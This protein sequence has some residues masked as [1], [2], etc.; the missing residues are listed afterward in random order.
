[1]WWHVSWLPWLISLHPVV[2]L[3]L[4]VRLR[5]PVLR[6]SIIRRHPLA[7]LLHCLRVIDESLAIGRCGL[8]MMVLVSVSV[9]LSPQ[10]SP[11]AVVAAQSHYQAHKKGSE[12]QYQI[13]G[14]SG[15]RLGRRDLAR[16]L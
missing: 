8:L 12:K 11:L 7:R 4:I 6:L 10:H 14:P 3:V 2:L 5:V 9:H 16:V 13:V 1:M 15:E